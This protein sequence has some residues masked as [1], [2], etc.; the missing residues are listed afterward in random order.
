MAV[1]RKDFNSEMLVRAVIFWMKIIFLLSG[2]TPFDDNMWPANRTWSVLKIYFLGLNLNPCFSSR[3]R[4]FRRFSSCSYWCF[5]DIII[6]SLVFFTSL[7]LDI[8]CSIC[9]LSDSN[10]ELISYISHL[11][12]KIT[13]CVAKTGV[14]VQ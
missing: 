12:L 4:S 7:Q 14:Y 2:I 10:D 1:P 5:P 9:R 11:F 8:N 13:K 3:C 6:S